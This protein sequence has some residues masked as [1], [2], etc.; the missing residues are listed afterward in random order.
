MK[1]VTYPDPVLLQEAEPLETVDDEVRERV[2]EM[3][4]LMYE[5]RGIGLAGNQVDWPVQ[6]FVINLA[7]DPEGGQEA[8]FINPKI[9]SKK[10]RVVAE[11]GC[12]SIPG[13]VGPVPRATSIRMEATNLDG[14]RFEVEATELFARVLQHEFDHLQGILF[15]SKVVPSQQKPILKRLKE[16]R[17]GVAADPR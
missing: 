2:S 4:R 15:V 6:V 16:M 14:E 11:E 8:V 9:V 12:L 13:L 17:E 1:I 3:F 5:A 10:G 7:A